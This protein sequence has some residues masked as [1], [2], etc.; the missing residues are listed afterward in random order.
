MDKFKVVTL[1]G[2]LKFIKDFV[3]IQ[4]KLERVG[5]VVLSVTSG[6]ETVPPTEEEKKILDKVHYKKID[7]SDCILVINKNGYIGESTAGE[8]QWA[9][10]TNKQVFYINQPISPSLFGV[11]LN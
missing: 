3:D 11:K 1:C 9:E 6:E 2:S 4:I 10:L 5:H 7:M 8:I